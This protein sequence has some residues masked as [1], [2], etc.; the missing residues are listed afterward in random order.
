MKKKI[1]AVLCCMAMTV[2]LLTG[3]GS[4]GDSGT[5]SAKE[6][7]QKGTEASAKADAPKEEQEGTSAKDE[8]TIGFS[9]DA[10]SWDPCTGFGYTGS[11]LYSSLVK[12]NGDDK[13]ENDLATEYSVSEDALTWTFKIRDDVVFSNKKK[14][15]IGRF[16]ANYRLLSHRF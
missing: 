9:N 15:V 11:P 3:C 10:D 1:A 8:V 14:P 6:A 12:V 4:G 16:F 5:D 13:L 7:K 2:S